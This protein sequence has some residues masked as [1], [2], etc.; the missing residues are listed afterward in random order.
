M[1]TRF[2]GP[3]PLDVWYGNALAATPG[4]CAR[5]RQAVARVLR[6]REIELHDEHLA[7]RWFKLLELVM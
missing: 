5:P 3:Q 6:R 2:G 4:L 7:E 1:A